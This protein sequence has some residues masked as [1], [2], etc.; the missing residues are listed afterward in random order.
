MKNMKCV[1]KNIQKRKSNCTTDYC[2]TNIDLKKSLET[3]EQHLEEHIRLQKILSKMLKK[4]DN[5]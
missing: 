5:K 2:E 4:K 3:H 1:E